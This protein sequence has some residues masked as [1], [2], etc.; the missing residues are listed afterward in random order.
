MDEAIVSDGLKQ[1]SGQLGRE[2]LKIGS[3]RGAGRRRTVGLRVGRRGAD[4][5]R[6]GWDGGEERKWKEV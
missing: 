1:L 3:R 2:A 6:W 5:E 4:D